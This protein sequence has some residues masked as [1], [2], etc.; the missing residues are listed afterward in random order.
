[1]STLRLWIVLCRP[2]QSR[3]TTLSL[4][5]LTP[6]MSMP[7]NRARTPN[8]SASFAWS[9]ISAACSSALV[10]M[11]PRCRQV[12]PTL[13][14]SMSATFL[15]SSAALSAHAYP[16][17]PPPRMTMSYRPLLSA[18]ETLLGCPRCCL[19]RSHPGRLQ[20]PVRD[21]RRDLDQ[22]PGRG[23]GP[24]L[25]RVPVRRPGVE[26]GRGDVHMCPADSAWHELTQEDTGN[27]HPAVAVRAQV[28]QVGDG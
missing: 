19:P 23:A 10:G 13:S 11:Q 3:S 2:F 18:T 9:A 22:G 16:P 5:A 24:A 25:G 14:F 8:D 27:E 4:Y 6:A 15:P 7:S 1:M 26:R 21:I 28:G 20:A 12:P 17:L